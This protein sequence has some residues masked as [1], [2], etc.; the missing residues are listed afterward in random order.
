MGWEG[1]LELSKVAGVGRG[2]SKMRLQ[3]WAKARIRLAKLC[4]A[5]TVG[6]DPP[7]IPFSIMGAEGMQV[8]DWELAWPPAAGTAFPSSIFWSAGRLY[9]QFQQGPEGGVPPFIVTLQS[10]SLWGFAVSI[11]Q[12]GCVLSACACHGNVHVGVMMEDCKDRKMKLGQSP[13]ERPGHRCSRAK[14]NAWGP[15]CCRHHGVSPQRS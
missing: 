15:V 7:G 6:S 14:G 9:L 4:L 8:P 1:P 2:Q 13:E 5:V 12:Q 3:R 10:S 11:C